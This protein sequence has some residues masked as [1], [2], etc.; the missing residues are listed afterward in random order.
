MEFDELLITTGV[1]A[2]VRLVKEKGRVSLEE[3]ADVLNISESK[4]E[5]WAHVLE[6]EGILSIEYRLTKIYLVWV[7]ATPA[8]IERE[9]ES[10]YKQKRTLQKEIQK[11]REEIAPRKEDVSGLQEG[12]EEFYN[13]ISSRLEKMEKAAAPLLEKKEKTEKGF[14]ESKELLSE[15]ESKL[16]GI[17]SSIKEAKGDLGDVKKTFESQ[18]SKLSLE[19]I[20][21]YQSDLKE[22]EDESEKLKK[23]IEQKGKMLPKDV[24]I[25]KITD[26]KEKFSSIQEEFRE[27]KQRNYRLREDLMNLKESKNILGE[28]DASLE[29]H[30]KKMKNLKEEASQLTKEAEKLNTKSKR[31][32]SEAKENADTMER[33]SDSLDVAKG[34][35]RRFP[36]QEKLMDELDNIGMKEREIDEKTESLKKILDAVGGRQVSLKEYQ[37]LIKSMEEKMDKMR[38]ESDRLESAL[39]DEKTTYFTFQKIKDR[40]EPSIKTYRREI[41]DIEKNLQDAISRVEEDKESMEV[42]TRKLKRGMGKKD[43]KEAAEMAEDIKEKRESLEEIRSSIRDLKRISDNLNKRIT[44]LSREARILELRG[45]DVEEEESETP[46]SS[47]EEIKEKLDLTKEEEMEFK[48]KRDELKRLIKKLWEK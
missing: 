39:E 10:F 16:G 1:D 11:V 25:P 38:A 30:D 33:F 5:E 42:E 2:L 43:I 9:R 28:I 36:S 27:I 6:E 45:M 35:L 46:T 8:E 21:K 7:S 41:N 47:P 22:L 48:K 29:N 17:K 23:R 4:I 44:L 19:R 18:K 40:L 13:R 24:T 32:M 34:I 26:I 3:A 14:E 15:M 31:I 12:F 37:E 20:E